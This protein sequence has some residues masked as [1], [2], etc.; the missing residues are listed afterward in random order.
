MS[1]NTSINRI[2][3][4]YHYINKNPLPSDL[5]YNEEFD[6]TCT[7]CGEKTNF[8]NKH[9]QKQDKTSDYFKLFCI[10]WFCC[11]RSMRFSTVCSAQKLSDWNISN[12]YKLKIPTLVQLS[13]NDQLLCPLFTKSIFTI[14]NQVDLIEYEDA[15]HNYFE[16][17]DITKNFIADGFKWVENSSI[18]DKIC[19]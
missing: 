14:L 6:S 17:E 3:C 1:S 8:C 18:D 13:L 5:V 12:I 16:N 2:Y 7:K 4:K 10:D 15:G 9:N 19:F 11:Y